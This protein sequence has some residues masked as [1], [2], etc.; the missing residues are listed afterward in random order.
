MVAKRGV[1]GGADLFF[2]VTGEREQADQHSPGL[3]N[4]ETM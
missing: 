4:R 1:S 3:V 2:A